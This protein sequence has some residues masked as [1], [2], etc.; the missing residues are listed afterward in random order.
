MCCLAVLLLYA[1]KTHIFLFDKQ[2]SGN[3]LFSPDLVLPCCSNILISFFSFS[4]LDSVCHAAQGTLTRFRQLDRLIFLHFVN[5]LSLAVCFHLCFLLIAE[6]MCAS[7]SC[8]VRFGPSRSCENCQVIALSFHVFFHCFYV[9]CRYA[10]GRY[11][12]ERESV[13]P[14]EKCDSPIAGT[15][16]YSLAQLQL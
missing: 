3:V 2:L 4:V 7:D 13:M 11:R 12:L 15:A 14:M 1:S 16:L 10:C 5:K 9:L 8:V 6:C